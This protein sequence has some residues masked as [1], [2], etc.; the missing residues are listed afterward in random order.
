MGGVPYLEASA[1]S[2]YLIERNPHP[3]TS[4]TAVCSVSKKLPNR[5]TQYGNSEYRTAMLSLEAS[6]TLSQAYG[7][8]GMAERMLWFLKNGR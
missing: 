2:V 5:L 6:A 4:D 7:S 1:K 8:C 3:E